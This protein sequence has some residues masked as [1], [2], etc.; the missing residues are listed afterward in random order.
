[1]S[2]TCRNCGT[3][4]MEDDEN[5]CSKCKPAESA[6]A[7][8][9]EVVS[10]AIDWARS[11]DD[12]DDSPARVLADAVDSLRSQIT[13]MNAIYNSNQDQLNDAYRQ[14]GAERE[15]A[16]DYKKRWDTATSDAVSNG[17]R[18]EKSVAE[19]KALREAL[20]KVN[21]ELAGTELNPHNYDQQD[22]ECI[23]N[24]VIRSMDIAR[25]ALSSPPSGQIK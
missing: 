9:E 8:R 5:L 3:T 14:V 1:M 23:N 18:A 21:Y 22:I 17:V 7:P 4:I 6:P 19:A 15:R 12:G 11:R 25:A 24:A 10:R 13:E 2:Y 16:D 20:A